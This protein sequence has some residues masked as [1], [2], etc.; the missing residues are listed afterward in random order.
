MKR[1]PIRSPW[2]RWRSARLRVR[3]ALG[4][5]LLDL[6]AQLRISTIDSFCRELALQQPILSGLGGSLDIYEQPRELYRRA[7]RRT[8]E[9][10]RERQLRH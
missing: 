6:P 7:A 3:S 5:D 8:L 1:R 9:Q 2:S 4:W 10:I